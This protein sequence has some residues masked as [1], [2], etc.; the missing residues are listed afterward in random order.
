[1]F[2]KFEYFCI[3]RY[4]AAVVTILNDMVEN[5]FRTFF[6]AE[7]WNNVNF[8]TLIK[9]LWSFGNSDK[10]RQLLALVKAEREMEERK[11]SENMMFSEGEKGSERERKREWVRTRER[12]EERER[13]SVRER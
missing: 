1:M 4:N 9:Y 11:E 3:F 13:E 10:K 2:W 6:F 8:V 12:E 7:N 5:R